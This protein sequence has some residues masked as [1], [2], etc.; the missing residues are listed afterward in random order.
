M[1]AA[2]P[3]RTVDVEFADILR[4]L[5]VSWTFRINGS[6]YNCWSWE[7]RGAPVVRDL[8]SVRTPQ[9]GPFH[10]S[11]PPLA[12]SMTTGQ[13]LFLESGLEHD[14]V[15]KLDRD[16]EVN[17]LVSQPFKLWWKQDSTQRSHTLDLLSLG[18]DGTVT[19]WDVRATDAQDDDFRLKAA[20]ARTECEAVGWRYEVFA[21]F[22]P[23]ERLNY[24]WLHGFRRRPAWADRHEISVL[25]AARTPGATLGAIFAHDDGSGELKSVVWHLLWLGA[26]DIDLRRKWTLDSILTTANDVPDA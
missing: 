18:T 11:V 16:H 13:F 6:E 5:T 4:D 23:V 12:Y 2:S 21:G 20:V 14:L 9:P 10:K 15:H 3:A 17:Y 19:V 25:N 24:L 22:E 7:E 26:L 8:D 1:S